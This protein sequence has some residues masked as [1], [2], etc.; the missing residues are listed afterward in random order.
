MRSKHFEIQELIPK[1]VYDIHGQNA[2][3]FV[4][5]KLIASIDT[6]K[7]RFPEGT[8]TINNW[9]WGGDR[10]WSGLRTPDSKWYSKTS[11]HSLDLKKLIF[12]ATDSVFSKYETDIIRQ[13]IINNPDIYPHI[14]G[15]ELG[16]SWLHIDTRERE[17]L[18]QFRA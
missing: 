14:K 3:V 2:W 1:E 9:L 8:M 18:L 12:K 17:S 11:Q 4:C 10:E 6:I 7:E 5:P 13:D 16:V 15:I